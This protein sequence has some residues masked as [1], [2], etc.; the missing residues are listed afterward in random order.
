MALRRSPATLCLAVEASTHSRSRP[1]TA[2]HR[3]Q[4]RALR[5]RFVNE[6][7][8]VSR[9]IH[10]GAPRDIILPLTGTP[11]IECRSGGATND[12]QVVF[13][14]A[15]AVTFNNAAVT[16]GAGSVSSSSG[17]GTTIVTV[18]LTGV[19]TAQTITVKL[20]SVNKGGD[21]PVQMSVLVGDTTGNGAVNSSDVDQTKMNSGQVVDASNFRTDVNVN[22]SINASDVAL[23]KANCGWSRPLEIR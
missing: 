12:Y 22:G 2:C 10:G 18:N 13:T 4:L 14:F 6:T 1:V 9:K 7:R 5:S 20:F 17:S 19:S 15:S 11:G 3:T 23:V 21:L 16:A 8:V